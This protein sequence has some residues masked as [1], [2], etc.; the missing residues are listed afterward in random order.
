MEID[1][2]PTFPDCGCVKDLGASHHSSTICWTHFH[3]LGFPFVRVSFVF[4]IFSRCFTLRGSV[5]YLWGWR[6]AGLLV[7][8]ERR[9]HSF[10]CS[11]TPLCLDG[12]EKMGLQKRHDVYTTL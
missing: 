5:F 12:G 3:F 1:N 11:G 8:T 7:G 9:L 4:I 10:C 6:A 2:T